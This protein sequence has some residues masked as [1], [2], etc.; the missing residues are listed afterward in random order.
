MWSLLAAKRCALVHVTECVGG[1]EHGRGEEGD[2]AGEEGGGG[3]V[4][5]QQGLCKT[6]AGP[7]PFM[8]SLPQNPVHTKPHW[9]HMN[10]TIRHMSPQT[11]QFIFN[12]TLL[13]LL[14]LRVVSCVQGAS[15]YYFFSFS[16]AASK[17]RSRP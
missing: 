6:K 3:G 14:Q 12:W 9:G 17:K 8:V 10:P 11:L 13:V 16:W 2:D 15:P 7:L 5:M 1:R 4:Q